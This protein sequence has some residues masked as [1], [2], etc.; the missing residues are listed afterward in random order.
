MAQMLSTILY[1]SVASFCGQ[2]FIMIE[3]DFT[4]KKGN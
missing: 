3:S 4:S 1:L 2:I